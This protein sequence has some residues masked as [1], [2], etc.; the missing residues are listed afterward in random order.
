MSYVSTRALR[1]GDKSF[2]RPSFRDDPK[3]PAKL[4]R[5]VSFGRGRRTRVRVM[6]LAVVVI[7][8]PDDSP[9]A[10]RSKINYRDHRSPTGYLF[11]RES[12]NNVTGRS[13][14]IRLYSNRATV[15]TVGKR[16]I[17]ENRIFLSIRKGRRAN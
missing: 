9:V 8:Q 2:P 13:K 16:G 7:R 12:A 1:S 5:R 4:S 3:S 15:R 17:D 11:R 6:T 14:H 10:V